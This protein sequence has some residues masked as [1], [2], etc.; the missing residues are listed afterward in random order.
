MTARRYS[1]HHL[2]LPPNAALPCRPE[3]SPMKSPRSSALRSYRKERILRS[4]LS[5]AKVSIIATQPKPDAA[6]PR[7]RSVSAI[8]PTGQAGL[9]SSPSL[10][11]PNFVPRARS[12]PM[13][14]PLESTGSQQRSARV[15]RPLPPVSS[16]GAS[17]RYPLGPEQMMQQAVKT[18]PFVLQSAVPAAK[19]YMDPTSGRS[20]HLRCC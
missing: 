6:I 13:R 2:V 12:A 8:R 17:L 14:R 1:G 7:S 20:I 19:L 4:S 10:L 9:K 11:P 3:N 5:M 15:A 16:L 18:E